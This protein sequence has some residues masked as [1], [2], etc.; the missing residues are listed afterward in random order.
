[1]RI[2]AQRHLHRTRRARSAPGR[3]AV[4]FVV[5]AAAMSTLTVR[6]VAAGV[7]P[8]T[9]LRS[10]GQSQRG[11]LVWQEWTSGDGH[12]C[13]NGSGDGPGTFPRPIRVSPGADRARFVLFRRQRPAEVTITA[14]HRLG[15][16]GYE[17]GPSEELPRSLHP[18][19]D[20]GGH[21]VAWVA[22]F[23]VDLPPRYYLHLYA[24][25]P[26]G[27]CGGPRHLLRT[28]S[29]AGPKPAEAGTR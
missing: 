5:L 26:N 17:T 14:W 2:S 18:R 4:A 11:G 29:I 21:V 23:S 24:R 28:Y 15:P 16:D 13:V 8:R 20:G 12:M 10:E 1:M 22:G 7:A 19:R 6:A 9:E 25:W 3:L 27:Q